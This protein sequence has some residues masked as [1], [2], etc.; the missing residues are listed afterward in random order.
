MKVDIE[1][2]GTIEVP[3]E[4]TYEEIQEA[5]EFAVGLNGQ[6]ACDNPVGDEI[7][8]TYGNVEVRKIA[9][10]RSTKEAAEE[11]GI[12]RRQ[13]SHAINHVGKQA[14]GYL[15]ILKDNY[16]SNT[17]YHEIHRK[18][19]MRPKPKKIAQYTKDGAF[20]REWES[21]TEATKELGVGFSALSGCLHGRYS[22]AGG[23]IWKFI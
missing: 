3:D 7:D 10:Y 9:E 11:T 15:W 2:R 12:D 1:I 13:I 23:F 8:W 14:Q 4:S 18:E 20:I 6:M 22:Q 19:S 5:V 21:L 16:D 17:N